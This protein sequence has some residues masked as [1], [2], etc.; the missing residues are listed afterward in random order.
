M[1]DLEEQYDPSPN[2]VNN[3]WSRIKPRHRQYMKE[4]Y[5]CDC[6]LCI[7]TKMRF[8]SV[9]LAYAWPQTKRHSEQK[10]FANWARSVADH[11]VAPHVER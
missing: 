11:L 6:L 2:E 9:Q 1:T 4:P 7:G 8:K 10:A 3:M 5:M